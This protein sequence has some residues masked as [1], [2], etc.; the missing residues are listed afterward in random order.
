MTDHSNLFHEALTK[1]HDIA[2]NGKRN[3]AAWLEIIDIVDRALQEA[4]LID[5]HGEG[6]EK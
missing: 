2:K 1:V 5:K 3:A 6:A 4:R